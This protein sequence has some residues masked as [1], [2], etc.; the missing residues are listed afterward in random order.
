MTMLNPCPACG[1]SNV[2][3]SGG[4]SG[5]HDSYPYNVIV[6]GD[7]GHRTA[8]YYLVE[9]A[10]ENWNN[11]VA[12]RQLSEEKRRARQEEQD[13]KEDAFTRISEEDRRLLGIRK[14]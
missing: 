3:K 7:C 11:P 5:G 2:K 9:D 12:A 14:P 13:R 6:C 1:S 10:V 8:S 4:M